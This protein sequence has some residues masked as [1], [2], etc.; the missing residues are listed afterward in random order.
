MAETYVR[1][2]RE[3]F[4]QAFAALLPQGR[5]W[6]RDS[7]SVLM[8]VVTGLAGVWGDVA[9]AA[10]VLLMRESFPRTTVVLLPEWE[11]SFGLPDD[12]LSEPLT[13]AERQTALVQRMTMQGGQSRAF[14]IAEAASIG[15][16]IAIREFSPYTCGISRCGDTT[17]LNPDEPDRDRWELGP[18]EIRFYW[19]I[20]VDTLRLSYERTGSGQCGV[21]RLLTIGLATDLECFLRRYKPAHT[22]IIFDYSPLAL[23]DFSKPF[24]S[25]YLI[26]G[27]V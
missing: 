17:S 23:L 15:Y 19:R 10:D 21:D 14:F 4:A 26:L 16:T 18:A 1:H 7:D 20:H 12:C 5:A 3:D 25:G 2:S 13:I 24:N 8:Q 22:E 11:Q 27:I 9:D 6:P